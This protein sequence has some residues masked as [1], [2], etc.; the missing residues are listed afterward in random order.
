MSAEF[1]W[2]WD[3]ATKLTGGIYDRA[4]A[5]VRAA[6]E[7]GAPASQVTEW[8]AT[9]D[10]CEKDGDTDSAEGVAQYAREY[11]ATGAFTV[12]DAASTR[13]DDLAAGIG[14]GVGAAAGEVA[15]PISRGLAGVLKAVPTGALVVGLA[16]LVGIA[17][18]VGFTRRGR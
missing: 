11:A 10:Q 3:Q 6:A 15:A 4:R 12:P 18:V 14:E 16:A 13:S 1:S 5:E 17:F 7:R 2:W 9:L 8:N